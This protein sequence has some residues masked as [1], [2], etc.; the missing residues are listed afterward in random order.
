MIHKRAC[1]YQR[2]QRP[3][4]KA[5][6][7]I[8]TLYDLSE[9]CDFGEHRDENIRNRIVVGILDK[10]LSRRLQLMSDL[11]LAQTIQTVRQCEEVA[12]QVHQQEEACAAI[13]EIAEGRAADRGKQKWK[14]KRKNDKEQGEPKCGRCGKIKHRRQENCPAIKST[15]NKC[16]KVG[17]W[18][19]MCHSRSVREVTET[20]AQTQYF[21]GAVTN[22]QRNDEQWSVKISIGKTPVKFKIDTGADAN[23]M[24]EET[25]SMLN[26]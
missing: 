13:Q 26:P 12:L 18:E 1:F 21:L 20:V 16:K 7:F 9:H 11:T 24:C 8:R 17:H 14:P 6:T 2:A 19:R 4:E 15:C 10:E 23:I 5:E 22:S 25:F 3:G